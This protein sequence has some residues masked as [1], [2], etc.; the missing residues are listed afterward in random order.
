MLTSDFRSSVQKF[1]RSGAK[2]RKNML[3]AGRMF[4]AEEKRGLA[5]SGI[6]E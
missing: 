1:R 3:F 4:T 5:P 2:H 6:D